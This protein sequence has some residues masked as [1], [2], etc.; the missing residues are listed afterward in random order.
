MHR[1]LEALFVSFTRRPRNDKKKLNI[2]LTSLLY[3]RLRQ[4]D[5]RQRAATSSNKPNNSKI[6]IIIIIIIRSSSR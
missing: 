1:N 6:N 2:S 3:H 5:E 4:R